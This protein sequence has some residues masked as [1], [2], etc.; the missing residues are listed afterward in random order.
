M[1]SNYLIR[2]ICGLAV[3]MVWLL[4]AAPARA[5]T[6]TLDTPLLTARWGHAA[7][8]L[9]NGLLLIAGGRI[10]NDYVNNVWANTND[11]ELY[12]PAT[13]S[14]TLTSPMNDSHAFGAAMLLTNGQVLIIGGEN[15]GQ[16]T[17]PGAELYNPSAGAWTVT[18]SLQQEREA[19][20][21]AM[22]P[23]GRVM[24][25][26][27]FD[28]ASLEDLASVEIYAP[29]TGIWTNAAAM[30]YS[31]DTATAT[32]LP[33]GKVLVAGGSYNGS[34]VT[35][36]I[37][38]NPANNTW[39]NTGPLNVAR[40]SH[41]AT[42]LPNGQVLVVGGGDNSAEIY[43]PTTGTW[44][45]V[46][47]MNDGRWKPSATLL[48]NGQV[49]VLGGY[50]GQTSAELYNPTNNTWTYTNPLNVGR[51][52][53]T[54]TLVS[55]GQVVV[56]GGDASYYN[57]PPM[58]DV[59]TYNQATQFNLFPFAL[60]GTNLVW[61][62]GGDA[63]WFVETTN[64]Y[65]SV[66]AAQSGAITDYQQSWIQTT[67]TGPGTLTF[68]WAS[69]DDCAN[70]YYEFDIDGSSPD[71]IPCNSSWYQAGP[72]NIPA[73]QH[74]LTWTTYANGDTDPTEAG[75]LDQVSFV[76]ASAPTLTVTASP[77][78]GLVPLAVQFTSPGV[79]SFGNTV[80]NWN[81]DFG[82][83]GT[84]TAQSPLHS[85]TNFG[86]FFP[87]LTAYSTFGNSPLSVTG[88]G[89]I[90]VTNLLLDVTFT[91]QS[92]AA[93]LAVQFAS[94][95]VDSGGSTVTNW[96]WSFGDGGTSTAQNPLHIYTGLGNFSPSLVARST[97]DSTPLD[98]AGLGVVTV[99]N[100]PNPNFHTLYTFSPAFGSGPNGGL[101]LSGNTLYG[102][103]KHGG[104]SGYGTVF[105]INTDASGFTNLFNN[106]NATFTNGDIPAGGVILSGS[107][108]YG[109]TYGGGLLGGGTV[110]AL[111]TNGLGFTN[112]ASFD[113]NVNPNSPEEP[114]ASVVLLGNTLYGTT[115]FGG[116]YD[117]GTIYYVA[118][119]GSTSG[120]LHAFYTP[121][122]TPYINNYD[123]V[124][125]SARLTYSGG[126][127]YGTAENGGIYGGGTV[128]SVI[129]N[130]PGSFGVLHYFSTP[131][132]GTNSDGAYSWSGLVLSGTNLYGTT[133]GGGK[134]GNGTIFAVSTN[135]LFFTNL[136]SF[137]GGNDGSG[138]QG[139]LTLS[140]GTL[141]GAT[142]TGG[143]YT[144][145]TIFAI[146]TDGSNFRTLYS[147]TG[148]GDGGNSGA[149]LLLS[150]N[151][152]YGTAA[153][154]GEGNGT[155]FSFTLGRPQLAIAR[156][157]TNVILTWSASIAGYNLQSS[158]QINTAAVWSAV[159][160]L[161]VVVNSLNTVTNA[162]G[163][164]PKFYRLSQ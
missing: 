26:G 148:G 97:H 8:L 68:H 69:Q 66:M 112:L 124:Y 131:V 12:N 75:Y 18:G 41:A 62:T 28:N 129:T 99:T 21:S 144:N 44:A 88:P 92:G 81:W 17:I 100:P 107:T 119:N 84:S 55:F 118:T 127:L 128:F 157:G 67:V 14:S 30:T 53:H 1:N 32:L 106:F 7:T 153:G 90:T 94:P 152:L 96:N 15:N 9:T 135:G 13:G 116:S 136:Y 3:M 64:T 61:T 149:D 86:S 43:N 25:A 141:Y 72:F 91:P 47:P 137:T 102:T 45:L 89:T 121:S 22:L 111:G 23:D 133:S 147:F 87:S 158:P 60:N 49:L 74:T 139:G 108:L 2:N 73:G 162:I 42:V 24:V 123:G 105:A 35:N 54:A 59:E 80:T 39:T 113:L 114:Q 160:P 110:F 143:A 11:C 78:D 145:G 93:P 52:D 126:T 58:A 36:A 37:L 163:T 120:I 155:I 16:Y 146:G 130:Q 122:Y 56:A 71:D 154:G 51:I 33:N 5:Q 27:G 70:F 159:S 19:F 20:A 31:N 115:W 140:G 10:A 38:Y 103:T 142:P 76:T 46:A 6:F 117:H 161:P 4:P 101:V 151:T 156:S 138:P 104:I 65:D 48:P 150:G 132:N 63:N 164:S 85:Y 29:N 109:S 57:G 50:P 98:V 125:P 134:Y 34:A 83:G 77:A 40:A 79:D 82:D 95:G